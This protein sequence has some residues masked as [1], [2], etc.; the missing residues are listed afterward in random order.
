MKAI[1]YIHYGPPEV[2]YRQEL[3]CGVVSGAQPGSVAPHWIE[4]S[5]AI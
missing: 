5:I 2:L 4:G 3:Q 1:V